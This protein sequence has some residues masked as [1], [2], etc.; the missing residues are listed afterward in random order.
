M[1]VQTISAAISG[2]AST[3]VGSTGVGNRAFVYRG[4]GTYQ[5]IAPIGGY[6]ATA[7]AGVSGDGS[8]VGGWQYIP[9]S[10]ARQAFRWTAQTGVQ[11]L[12]VARPG[13]TDSGVN[14]VSRDGATIV[15]GSYGAGSVGFVWRQATGMVALPALPG[16]S[17]GSARGVTGDGSVIVGSADGVNHAVIWRNGQVSDLGLPPGSSFF[18]E[19]DAVNDLGTVVV[20][21]SYDGASDHASIW[22]PSFGMEF[23]S[24]YLLRNGIQVPL[25]WTLLHAT[26]VS[27][28]GLTIAGWGSNASTGSEG[29]VVTIPAPSSLL[30]LS[31][32]AILATRR[33][34]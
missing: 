14:A 10:L 23:L 28:D 8:V 13:D 33:R 15:G 17:G 2:D 32:G 25:G 21:Y 26:A 9:Q 18:S 31:V 5:A 22:T 30:A 12:G 20:G 4:P 19:A 16:S 34:R 3:V 7:A 24:D 6:T 29:F 27:A 1:P 11:N